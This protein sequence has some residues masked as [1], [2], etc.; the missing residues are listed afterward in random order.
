MATWLGY[1]VNFSI[2]VTVL[3]AHRAIW[4]GQFLT[5]IWSELFP[6]TAAVCAA[7]H[8]ENPAEIQPLFL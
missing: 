7:I 4:E 5:Q 6:Q 8:P 2:A 1:G 3:V